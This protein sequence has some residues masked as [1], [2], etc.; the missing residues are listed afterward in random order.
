MSLKKRMFR[1][2]MAILFL[3]LLALMAIIL[4][5]AVVF[6]DSLERQ[7]RLM[8]QEL[9]LRYG[10]E[11]VVILSEGIEEFFRNSLST[12]QAAFVVIG[13]GGIGAI[14]LLASV[15]TKR[16]N[17]LV[18]EP[19]DELLQGAGRIRDGN[20]NEEIAY[21]GEEEFE[22]VCQTFN[23]MQRRIRDE[24]ERRSRDEKA[25]IDMVT[26]ISHDLRTPLTSVQG[27][28]KGI[29]DHV[30]DT[31]KKQEAY[32]T[33]ALEA[34]EEMN[35][36]LQKLFDFSRM[37]SGQIPFH[38]VPADLAEFTA[39]YIARKEAALE[40]IHF[41]LKKEKGIM[42]DILMDVEQF[43]RIYDNLLENSRKYAGAE[44]LC[45]EIRI[46]TEGSDLLMSW[47]D[48]GAGVPQEKLRH[49]FDKFYQCDEA[50][51]KKGSGVGLYVVR[52]IAEHHGGDVKAENDQGI[53]LIFRFPV[54]RQI[55]GTL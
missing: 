40:G 54:Y 12:L 53:K 23:S 39:A 26:G 25:R 19:L 17:R 20:L 15:F 42:P 37:E 21:E 55:Q 29:L 47:K 4:V 46:Y 34:T 13:M 33:T 9:L 22:K 27:Y 6:E 16:M 14:L 18:T 48:N 30:A 45:V 41:I 11:Q 35:L 31:P 49:I 7:F 5:V 38:K 51:S 44:E 28:I 32:L 3:T 50:R 1:Y 24:Q 2:N 36:L 43:G 10:E 52:Y 8:G